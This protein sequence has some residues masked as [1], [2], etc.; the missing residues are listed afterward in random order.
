MET[1]GDFVVSL[2]AGGLSGVC[3]DLTLF[4][5]DTL[6]TR[7]QSASGFLAA[8][9]FRGVYSGILSAAVGSFP[10]GAVFFITYE[11]TKTMLRSSPPAHMIAASVGEVVACVVK[12]PVEVVKQ[13]AQAC[14]EMST[15]QAFVFT[16]QQEVP[17]SLVQFPLWEF[18]KKYWSGKQGRAVDPW[19]GAV[20]GA[21]SGGFA[22]ALTTP[23]DVAKT[24]IMLAE[25]QSD[26]AVGNVLPVI[27]NV[28]KTQGVPG[29]FAGILPRVL[30]IGVGG[31]I[32]LGS[33]QKLG[34]LLQIHTSRHRAS[35]NLSTGI[36]PQ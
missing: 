28:Y 36:S 27:V 24:R 19:Q 23:L 33:Y 17:F 3:V 20:C 22:A 10:T 29:L 15:R 5:L 11:M 12:V 21:L 4:P 30:W 6:K 2:L 32:F 25:A 7:L 14:C 31:F 1:A 18:L 13:R 9:G 16:L 8:G 35:T 34:Q 26:T